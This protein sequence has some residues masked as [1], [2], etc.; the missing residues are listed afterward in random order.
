MGPAR[1]T[2][3]LGLLGLALLAPASARAAPAPW[4]AVRLDEGLSVVAGTVALRCPQRI[5]NTRARCVLRAVLTLVTGPS[6][7][8]LT[9]LVDPERRRED[10]VQVGMGRPRPG[11]TIALPGG[12]RIRVELRAA[13]VLVPE[14]P[15]FLD[16]VAT[17]HPLML[18]LGLFRVADRPGVLSSPLVVGAGPTP[19]VDFDGPRPRPDLA[20]RLQHGADLTLMLTLAPGP[21]PALQAG[22][23]FLAVGSDF[24]DFIL[25][26]GWEV[27]VAGWILLGASVESDFQ[28]YVAE[29]LTVQGVTPSVLAA[30]SFGLGVG[31]LARQ[32]EQTRPDFGLRLVGSV[33][34]AALG[35]TVTA[36]Y[37]PREGGWVATLLGRVHL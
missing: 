14:G 30:P 22:G 2:A 21:G 23:P 15:R 36:D 1:S 27:G 35:V 6:G 9:A 8:R 12:Q 11:E 29:A 34:F 20:A 24:R 33:A 18:S 16:G 31:L 37:Y 28:R 26:G 32:G 17:R 10:L 13:R 5:A 19:D 25:R 3:F 7:G 4:P